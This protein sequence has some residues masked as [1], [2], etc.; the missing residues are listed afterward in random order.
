LC[1]LTSTQLSEWEAY[2]HLDPV[3]SWREDYRMAVIVASFTNIVNK[4]YCAEGKEPTVVVPLD[5]MPKWDLKA[6][7][8]EEEEVKAEVQDVSDM[9]SL[10]M[11]FASAQNKKEEKK[12][13]LKN[14]KPPLKFRK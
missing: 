11:A 3:G 1:K 12:E 13:L 8:E 10:L 6:Q 4:L 2:D 5:F 7:E 14:R 9:K